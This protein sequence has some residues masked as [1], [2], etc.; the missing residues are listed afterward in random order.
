[1]LMMDGFFQADENF[2]KDTRLEDLH[3]EMI[4]Y[5]VRGVANEKGMEV[6]KTAL[7]KEENNHLNLD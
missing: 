4:R 2:G 6:L 1:M 5:H 3:L 7:N